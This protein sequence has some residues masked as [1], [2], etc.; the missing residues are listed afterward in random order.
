MM[1][2]HLV[3]LIKL[4]V[5]AGLMF[6]VFSNIQ[7]DDRLVRTTSAGAETITEGSVVGEWD[8]P[9]IEFL[10][11]GQTKPT[12]VTVA[13][14][15]RVR[16]GIV[17]YWRNISLPWFL[18]GAFC[19]LMSV[20]FAATRWW[21]LLRVNQLPI[22]FW[23]AY[24]FTWIGIFFNNVVPGQTG[25]DLVKAI[26]VMKRC[27]GARVPALMS[28]V[29][30]RIMG[31]A[32]LSLLAAISVLFYLDNGEFLNLAILLWAVLGMVILFGV[33]AFSRRVRTLIRLKQLLEMLPDRIGSLLKRI[34]QAVYFYRQHK[35]GVA[36]WLLGGIFN[37]ISSVCSY[38]CVG[39]A[40]GVGMP[41]ANY[42]V[43]IPVIVTVS[44]IPIAPNGWGVGEFLFKELF[45]KFG[46][47]H[48]NSVSSAVAS[49]TMGTRGVA[50]SI[51]YR[52]HLTAWSMVG[53]VL[54][55]L[56][57]D[58]VSRQD[59]AAEAERGPVEGAAAA[60]PSA[61]EESG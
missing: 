55:F 35:R 57:K 46:A 27:E 22:A 7:L 41:F 5:V 23:S 33:V 31:L 2:K 1:N 21:W 24:R 12:K 39:M 25:G 56:D 52:I 59:L 47:V 3:T 45:S 60:E 49:H 32:S 4:L 29:V 9:E 14:E 50:L 54:Y 38:A 43:L 17:T 10:E 30:D 8:K 40:L 53:G 26:Y 61:G 58:K 6:W 11:Q 28:V 34:D 19:Y 48:L 18:L 51:V 44:A 20:L 13:S 42:F 15:V 37:H 36:L 16:V